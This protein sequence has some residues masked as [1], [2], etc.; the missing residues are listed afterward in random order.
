M[1]EAI[2]ENCG[3]DLATEGYRWCSECIEF[4]WQL[5]LDGDISLD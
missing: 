1:T 4:D 5:E 3:N 2:C